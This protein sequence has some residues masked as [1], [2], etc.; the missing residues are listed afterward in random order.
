[1]RAH[2]TLGQIE[3]AHQAIE[4]ARAARPDTAAWNEIEGDLLARSGG[5]ESA[6]RRAHERALELDPS[7]A[8]SLAA[9]ADLALER[10]SQ[11]EA[12]Q[13]F[14]R[15]A[16]ADPKDFL[17]RRRAAELAAEA[18]DVSAAIQGL[19]AL[20]ADSP[21]EAAA[22]ARL[23]GLTLDSGGDAARA[24]RIARASARFQG[25][26]EARALL[27]RAELAAGKVP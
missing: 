19:E 23:A 2:A 3:Q 22:A 7:H 12:R 15:A 16:S 8:R 24:L 13:L 5:E 1:V 20:L 14:E 11:E 6:V 21:V 9:L 18:G 17:S 27:Q 25:G 4:Q 26:P 10:G